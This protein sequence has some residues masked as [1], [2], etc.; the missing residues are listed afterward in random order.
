MSV[1]VDWPDIRLKDWA[2]LTRELEK[3]QPEA[4]PLGYIFRGQADWNWK[5]EPQLVRGAE[6]R[7]L[8]RERTQGLERRMLAEFKSQAHLHLSLGV[9]QE[10]DTIAW[11][12]LMQ[13][14]RGPTRL[15]DWTASPLVGV[16][17]AVGEEPNHD[18]AVWFFRLETLREHMRQTHPNYSVEIQPQ[19]ERLE[20][21]FVGDGVPNEI[22]VV[23]RDIMTDRMVAQQGAFT[24]CTELISNHGDRI[25]EAFGGDEPQFGR[26]I[27][28]G[29]LKASFLSRLRQANITAATLFPGADGLGRSLSELV[30]MEPVDVSASFGGHYEALGSVRTEHGQR[31]RE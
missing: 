23:K 31:G 19:I 20:G 14:Y 26:W 1:R 27:I 29:E 25:A 12:A 21:L 11:W 4:G 2:H 15:L 16:Y 13:H 18:G 5:L 30:Q 8:S 22:H 10:D 9:L 28:D 3:L 6:K 7:G 17:F 24:L